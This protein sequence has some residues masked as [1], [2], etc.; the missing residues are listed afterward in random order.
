M[1]QTETFEALCHSLRAKTS[2]EELSAFSQ[3]KNRV[4]RFELF[5]KILIT[6][7]VSSFLSIEY[8]KNL[9][10]AVE[11]KNNGNTEFKAERFDAALDSY[12]YSYLLTPGKSRECAVILGNRSA[13]LFHLKEYRAAIRDIDEAEVHFDP[14]T[15]HKLI[16]RKAKCY[17][18]LGE[19]DKALS[20]FK[21][22]H[23]LVLGLQ[24]PEKPKAL[25]LEEA[26]TMIKSLGQLESPKREEVEKVEDWRRGEFIDKRYKFDYNETEGRFAVCTADIPI[27]E[28]ILSETPF[29]SVVLEEYSHSHCQLCCKRSVAPL[30]C[31]TCADVVYCSNRCKQEA[32][33]HHFE[34]GILKSFWRTKAS[35][36]CHL[37]M[38]MMCCYP[39]E[40]FIKI[41]PDLERKMSHAEIDALPSRDYRKAYALVT[42]EEN[43]TM[44]EMF[45]RSL[46]AKFLLNCLA[47]KGYLAEHTEL[48][49]YIGNL[50]LHNIQVSL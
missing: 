11:H 8:G 45:Q 17:V 38:R 20:E 34:C 27:G 10:S 16:Q 30:A 50:I 3:E 18:E 24:M 29:C 21:R 31:E 36:T 28:L 4:A 42:H 22:L 12:N 25:I 46:M 41:R 44:A 32:T 9:S 6:D 33:F 43:R 37:S 40:F 48:R 1:Q 15:V 7:K 5:D 49:S 23:E 14:C 19:P 47:S 39:L 13:C 2:A 35:V 26:Q